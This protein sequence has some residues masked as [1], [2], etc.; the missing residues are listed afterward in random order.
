MTAGLLVATA[1]LAAAPVQVEVQVV[2]ASNAAAHV[3]PGLEKM[4][5]GFR[6]AGLVFT[7]YRRLSHETVRLA[8]GTP[9][10]VALPGGRSA[11][12]ALVPGE[13]PRPQV[14][15]SVPPLQTTVSLGTEASA[16]VQAGPHEGGQLVLVLSHHK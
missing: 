8:P 11:T 5:D 1:L 13:H 3:D 15:V 10:T 16:F 2:H 12:L 7:S 14:S 6:Q 9:A 4:R